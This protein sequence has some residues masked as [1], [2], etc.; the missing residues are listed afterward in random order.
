MRR[1]PH[2][3][4]RLARAGVLAAAAL[5]AFAPPPAQAAPKVDGLYT[6]SK[7]PAQITRGP[8]GNVWVVLSGGPPDVARI[9]PSGSVT[10]YDPPDVANPVG[11]TAGPDGN[12]WVTQAGGVAR[13]SPADPLNTD[14]KYA[15]ADI[16]SPRGIVTG[17]DGNLWAASG[18]KVIKIPPGNPTG[19]TSTPVAGMDA[20]GVARGG[21][22]GIWIA[23]FGGGRVIRVNPA[24]PAQQVPYNLG[25]GPQEVA[26]GPGSQM[27]FANPGSTPQT[28]GRVSPGGMPALTNVPMTDPF[29]IALGADGAWWFA[30][31]A[32]NSL[33]RLT[34][35][36]AA[37]TLTGFP[38]AS[39]PRYLA[40]NGT[41][42]FVSLENTLQVARVTGVEPPTPPGG[43]GGG[44]PGG[45]G[46]SPDRTA[47]R[48]SA[49]AVAPS[50]FAYGSRATI[51]F[52]LSEAA[53]VGLRF[54]RPLAGR[55]RGR[56][57]VRPTRALRRARRCTRWVRVAS[58]S[59]RG[60]R[61]TTR[62]RFTGRIGRRR[63]APGRYRIVVS[64][65]D[66]AGN[67]AR[68]RT[69]YFTLLR[70]AH[71]RHRR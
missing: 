42:L 17:P 15:I 25:G 2:A 35:A 63:L 6:V 39:G 59:L 21:D 5:A 30:Q 16:V 3:L 1:R 19:F 9:T 40:A 48:I 20:R 41:A 38:A 65:R 26:A 18:D 29:G 61:G 43:G 32:G 22:G 64:A 50:R 14:D 36:G 12:L 54:E 47:P 31:F 8:D 27:A 57:C 23:D 70:P 37:T 58:K 13:F 60:A 52:T 66:R 56:S 24:N 49:L 53:S 44:G 34:P 55:R 4:P 46:G 45:G 68:S 69:A 28:I 7:A 62:L 67:R 10:E 11:I 33:T 51:R 71:R